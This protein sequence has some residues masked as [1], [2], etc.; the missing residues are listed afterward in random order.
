MLEKHDS[1]RNIVLADFTAAGVS[2]RI[3]GK[4]TTTTNHD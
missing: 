2:D 1:A 3:D 4:E